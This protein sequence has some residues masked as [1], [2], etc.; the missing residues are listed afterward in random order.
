MLLSMAP[1]LSSAQERIPVITEEQYSTCVEFI[2]RANMC[3]TVLMGCAQ[4]NHELASGNASCLNSV[5][6]FEAK[7]Q[8]AL[9]READLR[10]DASQ[11]WKN[12]LIVGPLAAILG[13]LAGVLVSH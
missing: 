6:S 9:L 7:L 10:E 12:P 11:P 8:E 4:S 1:S 2:D 13:V 5:D 3:H